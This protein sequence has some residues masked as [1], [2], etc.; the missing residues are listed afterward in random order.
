MKFTLSA[1]IDIRKLVPVM[2]VLDEKGYLS[3]VKPSYSHVFRV[4][5]DLFYKQLCED[6]ELMSATDAISWLNV[7]G[8]KVSQS[9][10][11]RAVFSEKEP[12]DLKVPKTN[13]GSLIDDIENGLMKGLEG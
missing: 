4:M 6:K 7:N 11:K 13:Q 10:I 3:E 2:K 1:Y 9:E 12:I 5:L 8:Y